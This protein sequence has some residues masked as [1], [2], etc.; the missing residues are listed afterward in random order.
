MTRGHDHEVDERTRYGERERKAHQAETELARRDRIAG[1][2][3]ERPSELFLAQTR[4]ELDASARDHSRNEDAASG[5]REV[6]RRIVELREIRLDD[7]SRDEEVDREREGAVEDVHREGKSV[8]PLG[9]VVAPDDCA[10]NPAA[11]QGNGGHEDSSGWPTVRSMWCRMRAPVL[12]QL[13]RSCVSAYPA[14]PS[15]RASAASSSRA[16]SRSDEG[17]DVPD[18]HAIA[19]SR[20]RARTP[21]MH[22]SRS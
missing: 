10:Q 8:R 21:A 1:E 11:R 3:L 18:R 16:I 14:A 2:R 9:Q 20:P 6:A 7:E 13:Y 17:G 5:E 4:H 15:R 19:R 12:S 22:R